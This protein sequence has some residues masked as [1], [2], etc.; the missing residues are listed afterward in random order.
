M[1]VK[2]ALRIAALAAASCA[3]APPQEMG[4][5]ELYYAG[6]AA[7]EVL[8]PIR[9][10]VPS[11]ASRSRP[12]TETE[13]RASAGGS[14]E[15]S[16][17]RTSG[18]LRDGTAVVP[19]SAEAAPPARHLGL[20]YNLVLVNPATGTGES[21]S[22]DRNFHKGECFAIELESNRSGYLYVLAKQSSGNW[23]PLFPVPQMTGESNVINP[24]QK[25]RVPNRYCFE[26]SD[27]PGAEK[28][29]VVVSR[30][31]RE[32]DELNRG[33]QG[34]SAP[35]ESAPA[36]ASDA[37]MLADTRLVNNAVARMSAE[38]YN[39]DLVIRK[40]DEPAAA[41][42]PPHAV[43]VVNASDRPVSKVVTEIEVSHR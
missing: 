28:L 22:A 32:L 25:V 42:E 37:V 26:I 16:A 33:I 11:A 5:R 10:T 6:S 9:R 4:A 20:R 43:Y 38:T 27:P 3:A 41:Q 24:G 30:D 34:S 31:V 18:S 40:I 1:V 17:P 35:V 36:P 15:S 21:V 8:P 14:T 13:P 23:T 7:K 39:R 19:V 12:R 29:F 2:C